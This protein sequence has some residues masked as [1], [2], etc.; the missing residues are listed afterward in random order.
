MRYRNSVVSSFRAIDDIITTP[1]IIGGPYPEY[2]RKFF[3]TGFNGYTC[4]VDYVDD[5]IYLVAAFRP[6]LSENSKHNRT[7]RGIRELRDKL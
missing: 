5:T 4:H 3:V 6:G 7:R 2:V 1:G